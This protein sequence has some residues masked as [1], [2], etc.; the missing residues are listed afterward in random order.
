MTRKTWLALT[1]VLLAGA[2]P[3]WAGDWKTQLLS[4][5]GPQPD[6]QKA[7][8]VLLDQAKS[9]AAEDR[10]TADAL[11]PYLASKVKD[12]ER[13]KSLISDYFEKYLDNDPEFG[14]LDD[15]T[16]RDFLN[17]WARWK[18][19]YP[20]V[21]DLNFL[22]YPGSQGSELTASIEVGLELLN[23]AY[24]KI[25]LG[26]YTL[27]GGFWPRGFHILTLPVA[28]L[29]DNPGTY[30]YNLDL[31]VGDIVVRKP[32]RF[33]IDV[34]QAARV[35][36]PG[37]APVLPVIQPSGTARTSS[38]QAGSTMEGEIDLYVGDT[39]ILKSRK[40][41]VKPLLTAFNIG[42]PSMPGQKPYLPPPK[43][44][45]M[46][47]GVSILDALALTYKT[48][49]ELFSKKTPKPSP[50]AY[51]KV[52]SLSFSFAK[53]ATDG[54]PSQARAAIHLNQVRGEILRQ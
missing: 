30:D 4:F 38:P 37:P 39:L 35:S 10:Q 45:P 50:P 43:T 23:D 52:T 29:V 53:T 27:E 3:V 22:S 15:L 8:Q 20:L 47:N 41:A 54:T 7:M 46:T 36:S 32:I 17:F 13:E 11:L 19:A 49:K 14:F 28:A 5:L 26:L 51:Q 42:G 18:S 9:T 1:V 12:S 48:I 33:Q 31:K 44:G 6:Y 16:H 2:W 24:Y 21:T 25:S 34:T 40:V